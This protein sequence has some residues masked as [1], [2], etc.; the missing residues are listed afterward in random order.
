MFKIGDIVVKNKV[1]MAPM[2][3]ITNSAFRK[4]VNEFGVGLSYG[5]MVSDKALCYNNENTYKMLE[6]KEDEGLV[7]MQLFGGEL[8][9]MVQAAKIIDT[10]CKAPIL[11]INMGCPVLKVIKAKAG[12]YLLKDIEYSYNLI[13]SIV[14]VVKKPVTVKLRIGYDFESI[15]VVEMAKAME[16]AGVKAIAVHGRTKPQMYEGLADWNYIK[17]VKEAVN[18]PVIGNGDIRSIYDAKRMLD[19]TNC[20]SVMIGRGAL[21]NPWLI[22]ECVDYLEKGILP[23]IVTVEDK[24]RMT[25][26]HAK[27]LIK[28]SPS[29]LIAMKEMRTHACW[30]FKGLDHANKYK[31]RITQI[32]TLSELINIIK[33]YYYE[34]YSIQLQ[35]DD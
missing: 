35:L 34:V 20:Y 11:D 4:I 24:L 16:L 19:E 17:M 3:G 31:L 10:E 12:S 9:S 30:Y 25:L 26:Y 1:V 18:I 33:D 28:V 8:D 15:I 7:S 27:E 5:E 22:K 29:E 2:A 14:E 32:E 23:G 13:K 6:V 21:G